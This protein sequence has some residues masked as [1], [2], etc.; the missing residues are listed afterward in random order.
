MVD[1]NGGMEWWN[2]KYSKNEVKGSQCLV[3]NCGIQVN[4]D[5]EFN[6][7]ECAN[8]KW[9]VGYHYCRKH[10][11]FCIVNNSYS[12]YSYSESVASK[13]HAKGL[14]SS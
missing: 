11:H 7:D 12:E 2:C 3:D 10:P 4:A 6:G 14:R 5:I 8:L 13:S 1:W 9:P